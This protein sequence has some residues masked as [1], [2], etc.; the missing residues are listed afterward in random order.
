MGSGGAAF[1]YARSKEELE[2]MFPYLIVNDPEVDFVHDYTL[3]T[4]TLVTDVDNLTGWLKDY[5]DR[6]R[7]KSI[8][9]KIKSLFFI[10]RFLKSR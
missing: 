2:E 5:Y 10:T 7:R 8:W 3:N 6:S 1:V 9:G 4:T